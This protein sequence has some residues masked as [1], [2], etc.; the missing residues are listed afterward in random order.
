MALAD[1]FDAL[2]VARVQAYIVDQEG[3]DLELDFKFEMQHA[4]DSQSLF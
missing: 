1:T 2:D 4:R 3:E